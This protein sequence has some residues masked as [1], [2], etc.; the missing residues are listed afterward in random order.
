MQLLAAAAMAAAATGCGL[1]PGPSS[2]GTAALTVTRDYGAQ[3]IA[4]AKEDDPAES[5]TVLRFL[6]RNAHISTRY[7]G[8][9]VQSINDLA[10]AERSGR[11]FDWFFY[12]NGVESPVGST[13]VKVGGG[14]RIW[15]DYRDWTSAM[16][17]PAVVGSWPQPFTGSPRTI[18]VDCAGDT[19]PCAI[20]R[21]RLA[22]A[23]VRA[24]VVHGIAPSRGPR[25][26]V[27]P[28]S[29]VRKDGAARQLEA[30][31][32]TSGVFATYGPGGALGLLRA[33]GSAGQR[34]RADTGVVAALRD[35]ERPPT[36]VVSSA[37]PAGVERAARRLD[38]I[39]LRDHYAI[40]VFAHA[41]VPLPLS[42]GGA[43]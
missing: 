31:P 29:A 36:W 38:A 39:D 19:A 30:G 28:W 26:L 6:D 35:G 1:G 8:G 33:D 43:A 16:R 23:D 18:E 5:E 21:D 9:F 11:R 41:V 20:A 3:K 17:V 22:R 27:G 34:A 4:S 14:D 37:R 32:A 12:V 42:P 13:Q 2:P 7:G 10:G 15:W 24:R 25:I 40:A